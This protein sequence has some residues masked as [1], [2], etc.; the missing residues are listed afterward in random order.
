MCLTTL[1]TTA[2]SITIANDAVFISTHTLLIV[3]VSVKTVIPK[4]Q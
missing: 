3:I 4:K 1:V 2:R